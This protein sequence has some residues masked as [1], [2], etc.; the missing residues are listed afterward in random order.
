MNFGLVVS[1]VG[2]ILFLGKPSP[3]RCMAQQAMYGLGFTLCVSCILTKAFRTFIAYV[4]YDPHTQHKLLKIDKPFV[5]IGL[6][7]AIQGLVCIFWFVFDHPDVEEVESK[8]QQLT[9]NHLCT[10]GRSMVSFGV[11]HVYIAVLAVV[12]FLLAFKGRDD[13]TE[14]IVFSMLIHLFAWLCFIPVFITQHE[15]RPIIQISAIMV[16]NYGVIFCH[17]TPKWSKIIAEKL[18]HRSA[19]KVAGC[20]S[21]ETFGDSAIGSLSTGGSRDSLSLQIPVSSTPSGSADVE[22]YGWRNGLNVGSSGDSVRI[23]NTRSPEQFPITDNVMSDL[24]NALNTDGSGG[25]ITIS[26]TTSRLSSGRA[27]DLSCWD[28]EL[29]RNS[30]EDIIRT[31][32]AHRAHFTTAD[33]EMSGWDHRQP[34]VSIRHRRMRSF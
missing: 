16:S 3:D 31:T 25:P 26:S 2:V 24:D 29:N 34:T 20:Q 12:C 14:P 32:I 19:L 33:S 17:F 1:F 8:T 5:I 4:A 7:T 27:I 18:E 23:P 30:S 21:S 28:N 15:L 6:L 22:I 10:Q 13:E 11:M 9:M